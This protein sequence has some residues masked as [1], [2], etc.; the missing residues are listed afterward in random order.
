[1]QS[2]LA[3]YQALTDEKSPIDQIIEKIKENNWKLLSFSLKVLLSSRQSKHSDEI[4]EKLA[5]EAIS[6][7]SER[8]TQKW[9]FSFYF[10]QLVPKFPEYSLDDFPKPFVRTFPEELAKE[11]ETNFF[12]K[13][14]FEH[15]T[16]K[17]SEL[18]L[19]CDYE[20]KHKD[21][22]F[23]ARFGNLEDC[24]VVETIRNFNPASLFHSV[25]EIH[26]NEWFE[27]CFRIANK[28]NCDF[29]PFAETAI[30]SNNVFILD[31]LLP[32]IN[33]RIIEQVETFRF[34]NIPFLEA[35]SAETNIRFTS[36]SFE[37]VAKYLNTETFENILKKSD[38]E[39]EMVPRIV[40][41]LADS[42]RTPSDDIESEIFWFFR[43]ARMKALKEIE[44]EEKFDSLIQ[45]FGEDSIRD[46]LSLDDFEMCYMING[47]DNGWRPPEYFK[48]DHF[49]DN[50][51]IVLKL[52]VLFR[53]NF[54]DYRLF[55]SIGTIPLN[56]MHFRMFNLYYETVQR[57]LEN[58]VSN[59]Y[60]L[61]D[62][63]KVFIDRMNFI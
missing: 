53:N 5:D 40:S 31:R 59:G 35:I 48:L 2:L 1:M 46:E 19:K 55:K 34:V 28:R 10:Q 57:L 44:I 45:F 47:V 18:I 27:Y 22:A 29:K 54:K 62:D 33:N 7:E 26:R 60:S 21:Y 36:R 63:E 11:P 4:L 32:V 3:F 30:I 42:Y 17:L 13:L 39:I 56:H 15:D 37:F 58:L 52:I 49:Y 23:L 8:K 9:R 41:Y 16:G 6:D 61:S 50:F 20:L 24:A 43:S 38:V 25:I 51:D 12:R 14:I